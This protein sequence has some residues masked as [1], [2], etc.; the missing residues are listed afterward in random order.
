MLITWLVLMTSTWMYAKVQR[1]SEKFRLNEGSLRNNITFFSQLSNLS[2]T[3]E[4]VRIRVVIQEKEINRFLEACAWSSINTVQM[5]NET[6]NW[7]HLKGGANEV[8]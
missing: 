3:M 6:M 7:K 5:R 4:G 8:L 1:L 2:F